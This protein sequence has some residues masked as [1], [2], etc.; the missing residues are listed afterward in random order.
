MVT[1]I[2]L[3]TSLHLI[4]SASKNPL[5]FI[6]IKNKHESLAE[7]YIIMIKVISIELK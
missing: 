7:T 2:S 6:K 3:Y 5:R 1:H 4:P